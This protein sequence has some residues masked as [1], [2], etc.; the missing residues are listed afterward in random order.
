[1]S[2]INDIDDPWYMYGVSRGMA[3][4]PLILAAPKKL[5][6][7]GCSPYRKRGEGACLPV[8]NAF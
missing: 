1:M 3:T 2:E 6:P 7:S 8:A 5:F 4:V